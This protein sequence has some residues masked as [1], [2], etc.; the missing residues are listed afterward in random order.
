MIRSAPPDTRHLRLL[1]P[2]R[3]EREKLQTP[4]ASSVLI[5]LAVTLAAGSLVTA[6][7]LFHHL[8]RA[9]SR[10]ARTQGQIAELRQQLQETRQSVRFTHDLVILCSYDRHVCLDGLAKPSAVVAGILRRAG[11]DPARVPKTD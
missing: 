8:Q 11:L 1:G 10:V 3:Q 4:E 6:G 2:A 5:G 7:Y 9:E